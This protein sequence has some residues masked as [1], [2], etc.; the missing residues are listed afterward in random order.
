MLHHICND[1]QY[2]DHEE[3]DDEQRDGDWLDPASNTMTLLREV[4]TEPNLL[5]SLHYYSR[6]RHT[7]ILE[8]SGSVEKIF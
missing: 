3:I 2:C 8:V 6:N 5:K 1:H 4:V 7:G